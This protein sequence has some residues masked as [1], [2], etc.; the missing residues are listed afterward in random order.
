MLFHLVTCD[1]SD[2]NRTLYDP[3]F[4]TEQ[5]NLTFLPAATVMFSMMSVNSGSST[6]ARKQDN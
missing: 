2:R 3:R 1:V 4:L 5:A 6:A